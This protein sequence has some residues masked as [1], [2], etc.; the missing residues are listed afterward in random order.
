MV[1]RTKK[2]LDL[3]ETSLDAVGLPHHRLTT[4][5][6]GA[7]AHVVVGT[8]HRVKGGEYR[9]VAVADVSEGQIPLTSVDGA[10]TPEATDPIRHRQDLERERSLLY[11][12]APRARDHLSVTGTASRARS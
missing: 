2:S 7:D 8:I 10:V 5:T 9:C 4:D 3:V 11:V 1:A 12:A 6:V